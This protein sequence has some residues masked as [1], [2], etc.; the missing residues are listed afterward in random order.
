MRT[1][2]VDINNAG[3]HTP[4]RQKLI[5]DSLTTLDYINT[6]NVSIE[7]KVRNSRQEVEISLPCSSKTSID[8]RRK[9]LQ[10]TPTNPKI[11]LSRVPSTE[12]QHANSTNCFSA[13][14]VSVE[15][16]DHVQ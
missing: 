5:K 12:T 2:F 11:I 7:H 6:N 15:T 16:C 9:Y 3:G 13:L 10:F 8:I 14:S 1:K 4:R